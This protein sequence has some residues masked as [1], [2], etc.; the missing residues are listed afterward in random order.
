MWRCPQIPHTRYQAPGAA[1]ARQACA[2]RAA[3][4]MYDPW[5]DNVMHASVAHFVSITNEPPWWAWI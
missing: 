2:R 3:L 4:A 1:H 5:D